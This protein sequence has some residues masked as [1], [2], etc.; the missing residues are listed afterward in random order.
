MMGIC[1]LYFINVDSFYEKFYKNDKYKLFYLEL[2]FSW[3]GVIWQIVN[4]VMNMMISFQIQLDLIQIFKKK[5]YI[6]CYYVGRFSSCIEL[7]W[8]NSKMF[9]LYFLK[10]GEIYIF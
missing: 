1:M 5:V 8:Y 2:I 6:E 9:I 3:R 10:F 7:G 4:F